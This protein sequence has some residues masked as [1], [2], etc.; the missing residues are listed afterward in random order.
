[1]PAST[2]NPPTTA[3]LLPIVPL[4]ERDR[5]V[6]NLNKKRNSEDNKLAE[7]EKGEQWLI[8]DLGVV[9]LINPVRFSVSAF[10]EP[11]VKL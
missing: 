5:L 4:W 8:V 6:W 1:M 2:I 11:V 3:V 10:T 9:S 7:L